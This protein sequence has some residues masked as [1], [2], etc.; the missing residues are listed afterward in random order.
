MNEKWELG[1][2]YFVKKNYTL[3]ED[4]T[5]PAN[6]HG[7]PQPHKAPSLEI[8]GLLII[9]VS[10][11]IASGG[12]TNLRKEFNIYSTLLL[13]LFKW[14]SKAWYHNKADC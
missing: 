5:F 7:P 4:K 9:W 14:T 10:T 6:L 8:F 3:L 2:L 11:F 12:K 13:Y 1:K